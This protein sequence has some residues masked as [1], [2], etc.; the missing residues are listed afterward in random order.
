MAAEPDDAPT[1][2]STVPGDPGSPWILHVPHAST[3]IPAAVRA[4]IVLDD[5]QL[6]AELRAMTD[7]HTDR[8][9]A[10][11]S[12]RAA[13]RRPWAFVNGLSRLV[14]DPE[15]FPDE[16]EVMNRVGMGA[17]YTRT[18]TGAPLRVEDP[19]ERAGL[20]AT[21]FEPYSRA[22]ADLVDD[23]LAATG[24][25]VI[26]DLHSFPEHALPYELHP[27]DERPVIC[28]GIDDRHTSRELL[29]A[30]REAFAPL[31]SLA[32]DQP[33]R[34]TYV[35]LPHHGRDDRV[36]SIMLEVR[37]DAYLRA[38]GAA[39]D[40]A[41]DRLAGAAARLIDGLAAS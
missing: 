4:R 21:Y 29:A 32:V 20:I 22:L 15:R 7:A 19:A 31:G 30:A 34:G 27:D 10:R 36:E 40:A 9:A 37:R 26:L 6:D 1:S 16:R 25:A 33:F 24:R 5:A 2:F 28:L 13:S 41:I 14:V 17:V 8:L 38:D 39:D 18:S 23:R 35:P 3:R 12:E 11:T